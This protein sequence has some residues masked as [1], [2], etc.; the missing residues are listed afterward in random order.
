[1]CFQSGLRV[2]LLRE[3]QLRPEKLVLD[4]MS[5]LHVALISE[6]QLRPE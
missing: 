1:V 5:G 6:K 4:L 2:A 3:K